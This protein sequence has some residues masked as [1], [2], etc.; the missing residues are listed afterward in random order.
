MNKLQK[1][2]GYYIILFL[3][4]TVLGYVIF[5]LLPM[6]S[7]FYLSFTSWDIIGGA[8][9]WIGLKNYVDIFKSDE[10]YRVFKNTLK[11]IVIY[12]P[13]IMISSSCLALLFDAK[14]KGIAGFRILLFIPVLTSWVAGSIIWRSALNG[15]YGLVNNILALIGID[16]PG[17]LT[18]PSWSMISIVM[19]SVWKDIGFFSLIIFGGLRG[20]D[21]KMYEAA[22]IDGANKL[23]IIKNITLPL[24]SPTLFFVLI[25]TIINSFQ[26]FPQVMVMTG[27]GPL[28]ST[29]VLVERIYVYGFRYFNMGYATALSIILLGVIVSVTVLQW[30]LQKKWVFYE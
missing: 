27:G 11:F 6:L 22:E 9:E 21:K 10:F 25:I 14:V 19:V 18:D 24:V 5:S 4:P 2:I 30:I 1:N 28:G 13:M 20:I 26:L 15:Q 17:W 3:I 23:Q 8:P 7:A 16:G 29:Q 12:I